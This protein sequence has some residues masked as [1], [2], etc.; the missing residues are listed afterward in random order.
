MSYKIQ[1]TNGN[2]LTTIPDTQVVSTYG[3]LDLIGKNY[4]GFGTA[5]NSDL[6][7]IAENFAD[8]TPPTNPLVGQ[9][10][11]DTVSQSLNFWTGSSFNPISV[12]TNSSTAPLNPQEGDEWYDNVNQQLSIWNG[13][14]W[15]LIGPMTGSNTKE[16][17]IVES[18][19]PE[20]GDAIY[21][22]N[23][24]ANNELLGIVSS[25]ELTNPSINGFNDIRVGLNFPTN[26]DSAPSVVASGIYNVSIITI[27]NGDQ[28]TFTL[29]AYNNA[30]YK[31]NGGNT[32]VISNGNAAANNAA[33]AYL[34]TGQIV[35][36]VYFNTIHAANIIGSNF[37][38]ITVPGSTGQI[39]INN[40]G[41]LGASGVITINGSIANIQNANVSGSLS[42]TNLTISGTT[43]AQTINM[44]NAYINGFANING[45]SNI[46]GSA[47]V[48][49]TVNIGGTLTVLS[50][51]NIVGNVLTGNINASGSV[52]GS[53]LT[54]TNGNITTLNVTTL[55]A[56][57]INSTGLN[58]TGSTTLAGTT[59]SS[60]VV[61]NNANI[62]GSMT[63]NG[64]LFVY[65]DLG[66]NSNIHTGANISASN[67][68]ASTYLTSLNLTTGSAT[69]TN[70]ATFNQGSNSYTMPLNRGSVAGA[71]LLT[72]GAGAAYWGNVNIGAFTNNN[73]SQNGYQ[74]LPSGLKMAWGLYTWGGGDTFGDGH[75][76]SGTIALP[77]SLFSNTPFVFMGNAIYNGSI[78]THSH[79]G[80]VVEFFN[81]NSSTFQMYV[82][83]SDVDE[84][85]RAGMQ[86]YW[87]CIGI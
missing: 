28:I 85:P 80:Y 38:G 26:P 71:A 70:G 87:F 39:L 9:L 22:L 15:L 42:A 73:L 47:N 34:Q 67:I 5:L 65:G 17:L 40:N 4:P 50:S 35:G 27:G 86:I 68:T 2:I 32:I 81:Q 61:Q 75:A 56:S 31:T 76:V 79:S 83:D 13:Y 66:T 24:Y 23:W 59:V 6:V 64:G 41:N 72:D 36:T 12:I 78:Q 21:Y 14:N 33:N 48:T 19:Q 7:H 82:A 18:Y 57:Q 1:L 45:S 55:N 74:V 49:G 51:A 3:G 37:S 11:Y 84:D 53:T 10:W 69:I 16:G 29:D 54:S 46:A 62:N 58:V 44:T 8:S 60:I 30:I 43:Y 77:S 63:I 52:S 25:V 20:V